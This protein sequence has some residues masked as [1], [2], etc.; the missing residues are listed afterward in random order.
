[1]P[2]DSPILKFL[3]LSRLAFVRNS[4]LLLAS[5]T[6][7]DAKNSGVGRRCLF[8]VQVKL[9]RIYIAYDSVWLAWL[10]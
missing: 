8:R 9:L 2:E 7:I 5:Q 10:S 1:M 4:G 6:T 3:W